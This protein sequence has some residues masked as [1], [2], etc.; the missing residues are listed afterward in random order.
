MKL[1]KS[2]L[3]TISIIAIM[4]TGVIYSQ[5]T[6]EDTLIIRGDRG[7]TKVVVQKTLVEFPA[8]KNVSLLELSD[9]EIKAIIAGQVIEKEKRLGSTLLFRLP[10]FGSRSI[11]EKQYY[12]LFNGNIKLKEE[13]NS[14]TNEIDII[15]TAM[16]YITLIAAFL[17]IIGSS[18]SPNRKKEVPSFILCTTIV[19]TVGMVITWILAYFLI[20]LFVAYEYIYT[21]T[22]VL[23][24]LSGLITTTATFFF[25]RML[26]D[27]DENLGL[28]DGI[29]VIANSIMPN[30]FIG[31]AA[32]SNHDFF[33]QEARAIWIYL[34]IYL[35]ICLV[36]LMLRS[37]LSTL[38]R[39]K[40]MKGIAGGGNIGDENGYVDK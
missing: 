1:K 6:S 34:G 29:A 11:Y 9:K 15:I 33:N 23:S 32:F 25:I 19:P 22:L 3:I 37:G 31:M 2:L 17:F 4:L 36:A 39:I 14:H 21:V 38:R 8:D 10:F 13:R 24:L 20:P 5:K 40:D 35:F 28:T 30:L 7:I 16:I 27:K 26:K 18:R 12:A